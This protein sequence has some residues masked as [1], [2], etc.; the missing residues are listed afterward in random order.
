M[1]HQS[2]EVTPLAFHILHQQFVLPSV[3]REP[4]EKASQVLVFA[5]SFQ[6]QALSL[7]SPGPKTNQ[8]DDNTHR[9]SLS[10]QLG[11]LG[12]LACAYKLP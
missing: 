12:F 1:I 9:D 8:P 5:A 3:L 10:R 4:Q 2:H 6:S 11:S 7:I